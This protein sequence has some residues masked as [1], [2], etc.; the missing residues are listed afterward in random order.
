MIWSTEETETTGPEWGG[1]R[2][3]TKWASTPQVHR[4]E[5]CPEQGRQHLCSPKHYIENHIPKIEV[6]QARS[7][8]KFSL[9][10]EEEIAALRGLI[11]GLSWVAKERA[12]HS[13]SCGITTTNYATPLRPGLGRRQPDPDRPSER[14]RPG[15]ISRFCPFLYQD[16]E[17]E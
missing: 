1:W 4:Q 7:A 15:Y 5:H 14:A 17:S 9:C 2:R 16:F 10:T 11:G 8:Q 6:S 12:R 13:R 3:T